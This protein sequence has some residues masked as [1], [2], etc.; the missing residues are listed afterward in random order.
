MILAGGEIILAGGEIIFTGGE[1][2]LRGGEIILTG[3]KYKKEP[4]EKSYSQIQSPKYG[5]NFIAPLTL[6]VDWTSPGLV[7]S[8]RSS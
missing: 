7:I 5:N 1:I 4:E 3:G 2:I 6:D 8:R